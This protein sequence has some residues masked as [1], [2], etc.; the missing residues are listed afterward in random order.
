MMHGDQFN[1]FLLDFVALFIRT[2]LCDTSEHCVCY[3][4][5]RGSIGA[6]VCALRAPDDSA[7]NLLTTETCLLLLHKQTFAGYHLNC[8][9]S[10]LDYSQGIDRMTE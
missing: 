3:L 5:G 2:P 8:T 9:I 6:H 10:I 7:E 4:I 1:S